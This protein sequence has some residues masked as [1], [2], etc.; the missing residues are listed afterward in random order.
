M[1]AGA[2]QDGSIDPIRRDWPPDGGG[3]RRW[4]RGERRREATE[5]SFLCTVSRARC[6]GCFQL[7]F[8]LCLL[9]PIRSR[10]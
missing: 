10:F 4:V 9:I 3:A 6:P 8:T 1:N 5:F 2:G 7:D